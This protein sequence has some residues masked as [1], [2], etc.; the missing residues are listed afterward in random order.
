MSTG[1]E[2]DITIN[3]D[4]CIGCGACETEAPE[5]FAMNDDSKVT[6]KEGQRD[7]REFIVD[8]AKSCPTEAIQVV[9]KASGDKLAP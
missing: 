1:H 5:T 4:E 9:D 8:A 3:Q 6:V 7:A 2:V